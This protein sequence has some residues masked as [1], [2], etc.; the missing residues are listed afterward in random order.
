MTNFVTRTE[1]GYTKVITEY[2]PIEYIDRECFTAST[3]IDPSDSLFGAC[4]VLRMVGIK[5]MRSIN[6]ASKTDHRIFFVRSHGRMA[7]MART[8][9]ILSRVVMSFVPYW[10]AEQK[11]TFA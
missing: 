3:H 6:V 2:V 9:Q 10:D 5:A 8:K 4:H 1:S 11:L 7:K